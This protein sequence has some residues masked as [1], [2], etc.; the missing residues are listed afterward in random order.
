MPWGPMPLVPTTKSRP[1]PEAHP[2]YSRAFA[3]WAR[4]WGKYGLGDVTAKLRAKETPAAIAAA[5]VP[6]RPNL[7][8]QN[9]WRLLYLDL[10]YAHRTVVAD[11]ARAT[12]KEL[13]ATKARDKVAEVS[14]DLVP[15][16]LDWIRTRAAASVVEIS[17]QQREALRATIERGYARGARPEE[18]A[19]HIKRTVG[20][21]DRQASAVDRRRELVFDRTGDDARADAMAAKYADQQLS[22]RAENI[23]RTETKEAQEEGRHA[24]WESAIEDGE[25]PSNT[26]RQWDYVAHDKVVCPICS[27]L[28]GQEVGFDESF[29]SDELGEDID[30]PPA[31]PSCMCTVTLVFP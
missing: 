17:K 6:A 13:R 2:D 10:L 28:D 12:R 25:L 27:E 3:R 18:L 9:A 20:L 4:A 7:G 1:K 16:S 8:E 24:A 21:T 29:Y 22:Y 23:A 26:R 5:V 30:R 14:V 15:Q 11:S 19:A 31:H